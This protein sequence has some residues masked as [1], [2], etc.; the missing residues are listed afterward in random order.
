MR[1]SRRELR[2][3]ALR[4]LR[5]YGTLVVFA[6][7]LGGTETDDRARPLKSKSRS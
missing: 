5:A 6:D 3:N 4:A 1:R 2:R 7:R